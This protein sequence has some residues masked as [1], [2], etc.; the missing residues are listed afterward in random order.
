MHKRTGLL[1][2]NYTPMPSRCRFT[3]RAFVVL[4]LHIFHDEAVLILF[5]P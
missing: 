1:Q 3:H 5:V 2:N 4:R